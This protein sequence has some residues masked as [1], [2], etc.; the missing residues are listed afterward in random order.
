MAAIL[1]GME[2][3]VGH[4]PGIGAAR[5]AGSEVEPQPPQPAIITREGARALQARVQR[6]RHQ[7]DVEFADRL[8]QAR[9][10]GE[11]GG[12]DDYLQALEEQAV[13]TSRISRLQRLLDSARVVGQEPARNEAAAVGTAVEVEDLSSGAIREHRLVGDYESRDADAVSA[14]SPIGRALIGHLPGDEV[15]VELPRGRTQQLRV[16]TVRAAA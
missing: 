15:E 6:L 7:L 10:F 4:Q 8:N 13:L 12:N 16:L 3:V 2:Q 11:I 14:S 1:R 9:G 5:P